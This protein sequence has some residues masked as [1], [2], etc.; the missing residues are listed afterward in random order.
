MNNRLHLVSWNLCGLCEPDRKYVVKLWLQ[1]LQ[2]KV[3][4]L[5]LQE[6]KADPFRLDVALRAILPN[7]THFLSAPID[8]RG[9]SAILISPKFKIRSSG[10]VDLSR[11]VWLQ[12][13]LFGRCA[14]WSRLCLHSQFSQREDFTVGRT[15]ISPAP[16]QLDNVWRLQHDG[17]QERFFG[18]LPSLVGQ[19]G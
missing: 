16:R 14:F 12:A 1:S 7:F 4:I 2:P 19:G 18:P 9:G 13:S 11:A 3:D 15:Q 17:G 10:S 5:A 8:G 6:T